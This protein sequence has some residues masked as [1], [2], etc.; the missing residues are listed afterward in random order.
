V[1]V[2]LGGCSGCRVFL[3]GWLFLRGFCVVVGFLGVFVVV[4]SI[5]DDD[6]LLLRSAKPGGSK[7]LYSNAITRIRRRHATLFVKKK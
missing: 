5:F 3:S 1:G 7:S 4:L 6:T 2:G